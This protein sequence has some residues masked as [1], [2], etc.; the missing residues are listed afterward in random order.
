[1]N[2]LQHITDRQIEE[3]E[4]R[5]RVKFVN[6][7][8]GF[9]SLNLIGTVSKE[10]VSNLAIVSSVIHFGSSPALIGYVSRPASTERHTL[11]N[12]LNTGTYTINQV[13]ET[14]F[15][16]AHQTSAR[17]PDE[18]S[19]FEAVGLTPL[20]RK[21]LVPPFVLESRVTMHLALEEDVEIRSNNTVMV[22]GKVT[23]VFLDQ[24]LLMD[25]GNIDIEKAGTI[26]GSGLDG[27]F[28]P[29]KL[30]RLSYAKVDRPVVEI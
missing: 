23:D 20:F 29:Q 27:Y 8:P 17:Y 30:A 26:T 16:P 24:S 7:L 10:G 1:M 2:H 15:K 19:E 12:I 14:F 4:Q 28:R 22:V 18:V 3:M 5:Q 11:S 25:D 6:S 21:G 9:K 13:S